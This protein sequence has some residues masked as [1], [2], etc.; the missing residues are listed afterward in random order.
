MVT[1]TSSCTSSLAT[2]LFETLN[3]ITSVYTFDITVSSSACTTGT[4]NSTIGNTTVGSS[5]GGGGG[6]SSYTYTHPAPESTLITTAAA[7][8]QAAP[9]VSVGSVG[10]ITRVL[11]Q[12]ATNAQVKTLQIILNSDPDTRIAAT[13]TGSPGNEADFSVP[14]RLRPSGSSR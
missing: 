10:T 9:A 4:N 3:S 2:D 13:G 8:T 11:A 7:P 5:R 14:R 6:G 12:G 1:Q